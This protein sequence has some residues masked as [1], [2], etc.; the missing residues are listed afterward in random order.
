ANNYV[1]TKPLRILIGS[2]TAPVTNRLLLESTF[3]NNKTWFAR[4][5]VNPFLPPGTVG[6]IG[7]QEQSTGLLYR[8]T[9]T[10]TFITTGARYSWRST[11]SYITGAHALKAGLTYGWGN[12][13]RYEFNQDAALSFRL[14]NGVPNRISLYAKDTNSLTDLKA[15]HGL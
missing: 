13:G 11:V 4:P 10:F 6:M 12:L 14:N 5:T 1:I 9:P 15:D 3:I 2:W 8:A 7:V